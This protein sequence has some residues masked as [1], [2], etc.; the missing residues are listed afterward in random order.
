MKLSVYPKIIAEVCE[1][2]NISRFQLETL[3]Y[4]SEHEWMSSDD[5]FNNK[6]ASRPSI[7]IMLPKL[8]SDGYIKTIRSHG[9]GMPARYALTM[10]GRLLVAHFYNRFKLLQPK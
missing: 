4:A 1:K 6:I 5:I 2:G 10:K 3:L 7:A 9:N 8:L